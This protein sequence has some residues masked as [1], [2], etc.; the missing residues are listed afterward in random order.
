MKKAA[1]LFFLL[2]WTVALITPLT[3]KFILHPMGLVFYF[4]FEMT[5]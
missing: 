1:T 2:L 5:G 4:T 3:V